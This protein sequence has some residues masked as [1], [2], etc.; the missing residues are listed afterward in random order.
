MDRSLKLRVYHPILL[1]LFPV[2]FLYARN[3]TEVRFKEIFLPLALIVLAVAVGLL[4]LTPVIRDRYKRGLVVS[5]FVGLFFSFGHAARLVVFSRLLSDTETFTPEH[6][7]SGGFL[8]AFVIIAYLVLR[9]RC[10]L[11]G[12]TRLL[13]QVFLSLLV[14]Q[15]V[16]AGYAWSTQGKAVDAAREPIAPVF[17][18]ETPPDIYYI[19]LDGYARSDVLKDIYDYDNSDFLRELTERGFYIA[20][21]SFSNYNSSAQSLASTLNLDYLHRVLATERSRFS[22][23]PTAIMLE[24]NRV[25][26]HLRKYGYKTVA[27]STGYTP[28]ELENADY[29]FSPGLTLSEFQNHLLNTTPWPLAAGLFK[30][31][32]D[33]YRER[34]NY[35]MSKVT[36]LGG[37]PSPKFVYAHISCPHPPFVFSEHGKPIQP[38]WPITIADGSHYFYRTEGTL[39]DYLTGYRNQVAYISRRIVDVVD[40]IVAG[41]SQPP[42][43]ILQADHGPG[44]RLHWQSLADTDLKERFSILNAYLLPGVDTTLLYESISPVNSFRILLNHYFGTEYQRLPDQYYFTTWTRPYNYIDV[45][46]NLRWQSQ[47]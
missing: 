5:L 45:T 42:V 25:M 10:N 19:I 17:A 39:D 1:G 7:V 21:S 11:S 2:L 43:I 44:S 12:I 23:M 35:T 36:D 30:S 32:Y 14:I 20:D 37:V 38:D 27:F 16:L 24:N 3:V 15:I 28:T 9:C 47:D 18:I 6:V 41:S 34:L 13:N 4:V 31:Q 33:L 8:A 22:R 40:S 26:I 29:Y 46:E